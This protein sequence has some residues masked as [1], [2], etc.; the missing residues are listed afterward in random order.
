M[1]SAAYRHWKTVRAAILNDVEAALN[2]VGGSGRGRRLAL[3]QINRAYAVLLSAEFQGFCRELH[4]ECIDAIKSPIPASLQPI[5][6]R[7]FAFNRLLDRGN[8][9]PGNI[10]ADFNRFGI[11]FWEELDKADSRVSAWKR[12]LE[13]LNDWRNAIAHHVYDVARLGTMV[14]RVHQV[15]EWRTACDRL[16][17]TFDSILREHLESITGMRPWS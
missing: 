7:E 10:G 2:A 12:S 5:I 4:D 14:L 9:N 11:K 15:R 13:F 17:R 8:P 3:Q 16:A 6:N 1:P